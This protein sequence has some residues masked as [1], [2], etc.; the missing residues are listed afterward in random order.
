MKKTL[1]ATVAAALLA[2]PSF[3]AGSYW[4]VMRDGTRY[5]AKAKWTVQNGKAIVHLK[6][7]NTLTLDPNAIDAAKSDETTRLGGGQVFGVEQN[8]Q[9]TGVPASSLG[10]AIKLRKLPPPQATPAAPAPGPSEPAPA[11]AAP[12]GSGL[13]SDILAKFERAFENVGIFEHK[14]V[15]TGPHELR[16]DI[17]ADSEEK[18]FNAISATSFLIVRNAGVPGVQIDSVDLFMKTTTG[19]ASGRF[20]MT[21]DDA[22][23]LDAKTMSREDYFVKKVLF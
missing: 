14:L 9:P 16:A 11:V 19:G 2:A 10:S 15:S 13:G 3:A 8:N 5:E 18:V 1:I 7:G 23:A 22:Q 6:N 20:H 17:T 4:V 21:R 12:A